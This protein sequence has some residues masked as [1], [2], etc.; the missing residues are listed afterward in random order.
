MPN[1]II[2]S[3]QEIATKYV[4]V[5]NALCEIAETYRITGQQ[6]EAV[7]VLATTLPFLRELS[8]RHQAT[9][10]TEYGKQLTASAFKSKRTTE[11]ALSVLQQ[12]KQLAEPL[13][14]SALLANTLYELGELYFV[15]GHKTTAEEY[16]YETSLS[17]FQQALALYEAVH[18]EKNMAQALLG[19]GRMYQNI[20]QNEAA[21]LY[22]ER[23]L[24]TAE[25]QQNKAIQ[26][27]ALNHLALLNAGVDDME[28]AIQQVKTSLA[29]RESVGLKAEIPYAYLTL[30]ELYQTQGDNAEALATYQ[31]CYARAEEVHSSAI[32]FALL[33]IGYIHLD[34]NDIPQAIA[35]LKQALKQAETIDLKTGIQE[36]R[37]ALAEAEGGNHSITLEH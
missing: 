16:D 28:T 29:I 3:P 26:A 8:P 5:M 19:V 9:F 2:L 34:N 37:E 11:E 36:A 6:E 7:A 18:D 1:P 35:Q 10:L 4:L 27:E 22:V 33:G 13:Q 23:A 25:Q 21:C 31:Q 32:V 24:T 20:G 14:D 17:Y 12:A 30:A 15:R